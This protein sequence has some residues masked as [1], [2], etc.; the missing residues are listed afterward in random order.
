MPVRTVRRLVEAMSNRG[1]K[2]PMGLAGRVS[3]ATMTSLWSQTA[4]L[5]PLPLGW[6]SLTHV[7]YSCFRQV[8][9]AYRAGAPFRAG[10]DEILVA[11]IRCQ[12]SRDLSRWAK[13][14]SPLLQVHRAV[15]QHAAG[16]RGAFLT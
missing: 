8:S 4:L 5:K 3:P 11:E 9:K 15:N 12:A 6:P 10:K 7:S 16:D 1:K 14:I 2:P 13:K